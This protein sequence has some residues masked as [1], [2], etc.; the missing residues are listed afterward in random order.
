MRYRH[1]VEVIPE[2]D[3]AATLD[4][5]SRQGWELVT[6]RLDRAYPWG[7]THPE[8]IG[9]DTIEMK[10]LQPPGIVLVATCILRKPVRP[11]SVMIDAVYD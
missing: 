7:K 2:K 8:R 11:K 3:L 10:A 5:L 9:I 1:R 6:T 4:E